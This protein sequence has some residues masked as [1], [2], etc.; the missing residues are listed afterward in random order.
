MEV[1]LIVSQRGLDA[2]TKDY[3]GETPKIWR[4]PVYHPSGRG[5]SLSGGTKYNKTM[6]Y[7]ELGKPDEYGE[8]ITNVILPP[9]LDEYNDLI[10]EVEG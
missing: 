9:G 1:T 5:A 8:E 3:H 4:E 6:T 10:D 7:W 2:E